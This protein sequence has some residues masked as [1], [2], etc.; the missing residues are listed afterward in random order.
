MRIHT[1]HAIPAVRFLQ[2]MQCHPCHPCNPFNLCHTICAIGVI[3]K[4]FP[5]CLHKLPRLQVEDPAQ[6]AVGMERA[7]HRLTM[8]M[9]E[10]LGL[11]TSA[12]VL[13]LGCGFRQT[14]EQVVEHAGCQ[15]MG[16]DVAP[17]VIAAAQAR[18]QRSAR[19]Q[20]VVGSSTELLEAIGES[21]TFTHVMSVQALLYGYDHIDRIL[22]RI[23]S[24]LAP[25]ARLCLSEFVGTDGEI[26]AWMRRNFYERVRLNPLLSL[27]GLRA[28]LTRA[29]FHIEYE[30][31]CDAHAQEGYRLLAETARRLGRMSPDGTPL[32]D[33]YEKTVGCIAERQLGLVLVVAR[34]GATA[35]Q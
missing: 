35:S 21:D 15:G 3:H 33:A 8:R 12:I 2:F 11:T 17:A 29:G 1:I 30:E 20:F 9:A 18:L 27:E 4:A 10:L 6:P 34:L 19:L 14:L 22:A 7:A 23:R 28:A 5:G 26:S 16:L 13:D 25:G 32:A 24:V 31:A